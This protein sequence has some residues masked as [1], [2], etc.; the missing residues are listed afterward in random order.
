MTDGTAM[1]EQQL[2]FRFESFFEG[3]LTAEGEFR[4][5]FGRVRR[6][7]SADVTGTREGDLIRIEENF[8]YD[9]GETD[10]REWRIR[11]LGNG[12][13]RGE[14]TDVIG[15]AEGRAEG[16][17]LRWRYPIR[18]PIGGRAWTLD[19][20]DE[21][22]LVD[23]NAL[24]NRATVRKFGLPVGTVRQTFERSRN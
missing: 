23:E 19:F 24:L 16:P 17:R 12:R 21:F 10:R 3:R 8:R 5:P 15:H 18:L 4:D 2:E 14:A 1:P 9:D 22:V 11:A 20:D 6:T 13:Y 7:F